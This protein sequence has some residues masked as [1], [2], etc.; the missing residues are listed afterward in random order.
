[1]V[2]GGPASLRFVTDEVIEDGSLVID[3]GR[4][5]G[6]TSQSRYVVVDWRQADGSFRIIVHAASSD[7]PGATPG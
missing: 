3:I 6:E 2:A 4:I 1:M 7:G 5:V